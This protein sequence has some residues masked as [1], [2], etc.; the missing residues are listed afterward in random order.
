MFQLSKLVTL[1]LKAAR[2]NTGAGAWDA[3]VAGGDL[4]LSKQ[5]LRQCLKEHHPSNTAGVSPPPGS[6]RG[7][8]RLY[9]LASFWPS[10][11][12]WQELG[13]C[14]LSLIHVTRVTA[15]LKNQALSQTCR[16]G[17]WAP[18]ISGQD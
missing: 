6:I 15:C 9:A 7:Q 10:D 1:L 3:I 13:P 11:V 18:G 2:L 5:Q 4:L 14:T 17:A 8:D 16:G 12:F